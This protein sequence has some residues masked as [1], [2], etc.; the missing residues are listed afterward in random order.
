ML[1][2]TIACI[3]STGFRSPMT[4]RAASPSMHRHPCTLT[5]Y[6]A[7]LSRE[8]HCTTWRWLAL[9]AGIDPEAV[10]I[11]GPKCGRDP[12]AC[13]A[14][15]REGAADGY[16]PRRSAGRQVRQWAD[17]AADRIEARSDGADIVSLAAWRARREDGPE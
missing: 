17:K 1:L 16:D 13:R 8:V 5:G 15:V 10:T 12:H 14:A 4:A 6:A 7:T 3:G 9:A 2:Q 11:T